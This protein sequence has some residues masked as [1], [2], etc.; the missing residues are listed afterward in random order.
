[1]AY[2][3]ATAHHAAAH[4][5]KPIIEKGSARYLRSKKYWPFIGRGYVQITWRE[6]DVKAGKALGADFFINPQL[7]LK[8]EY[9]V[10]ILLF[11]I[12]DGK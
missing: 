2:V 9:A 3:L 11:G 5:M 4:T 7:L 8:P 12:H 10:P 1:M 6:N